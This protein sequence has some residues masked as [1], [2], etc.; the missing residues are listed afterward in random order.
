M[1]EKWEFLMNII[2]YRQKSMIVD[3]F[4]PLWMNIVY[5]LMNFIFEL[6]HKF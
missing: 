6:C 5:F 2:H 4:Y 1:D 3:V